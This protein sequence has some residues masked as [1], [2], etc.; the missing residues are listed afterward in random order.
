MNIAEKITTLPTFSVVYNT[1]SEFNQGGRTVGCMMNCPN[2]DFTDDKSVSSA[3]I[4]RG[5]QNIFRILSDI[6]R[7]HVL[8]LHLITGN[9]T[10]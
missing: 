4:F 5:A 1:S 8:A 3:I 2:E 9:T 6:T 7:S 10:T